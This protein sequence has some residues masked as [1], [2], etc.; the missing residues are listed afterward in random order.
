MTVDTQLVLVVE[1][2][3]VDAEMVI[4]QLTNTESTGNMEVRYDVLRTTSVSEALDKLTRGGIDAIVLDL[5]LPD[6]SGLETLRRIQDKVS[7]IPVVVLTGSHDR[8]MA[9]Q[10]VREGAQDYLLKDKLGDHELLRCV[11]FSIER[12]QLQTIMTRH[13]QADQARIRAEAHAEQLMRFNTELEIFSRIVPATLQ[14]PL[15]TLQNS[16]RMLT[17]NCRGKLDGLAEQLIEQ[18]NASTLRMQHLIEDLSRHARIYTDGKAFTSVDCQE[19]Y[20]R[21]TERLK[22]VIDT[23]NARITTGTLPTLMADEVQLLQVFMHLIRNAVNYC[24]PERTPEI[25]IH[26]EKEIDQWVFSFS[27]NG[28][29]IHP[30]DAQKIFQLFQRL[31]PAAD[32]PGSGIGLALCEKIVTRHGGRIWVTANEDQGSTFHFTVAH[33]PV[34]QPKRI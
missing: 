34:M 31:E 9:I 5:H 24:P 22:D 25:T 13:R 7:D 2:D 12:Q 11:T 8:A 30:C 10:A 6:S 29:G 23:G 32:I 33:E 1:D 19:L 16:C 21:A 4:R 26:A 15:Q 18:I 20:T 28:W 14:V 3:S 27:D 17:A